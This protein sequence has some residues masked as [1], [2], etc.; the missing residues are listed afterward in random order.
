M[1]HASRWFAIFLASLA[2]L[3]VLP[4]GQ[5]LGAS[6]D[7]HAVVSRH[8]VHVTSVDPEA[9]LSVGNGDFAFGVDVTGLQKG[10]PLETLST[11]AWHSFPNPKGLTLA[12]ATKLYD[13]HGRKVPYAALQSSPAGTYF[14]ENP[15]PIPLGQI[16]LIFQGREIRPEELGAIDQRLELWTGVVTSRYTLAGEPVAVETVA[17]ADQSVIAVKLT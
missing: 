4:P 15:H 11:W 12:D 1:K 13:F 5:V 8:D 17:H 7:R 16:S 6:I 3:A 14:R 9:T 10:L 2:L